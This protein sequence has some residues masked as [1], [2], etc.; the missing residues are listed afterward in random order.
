MPAYIIARLTVTDPRKY[1]KYK[2]LAPAAIAA[3]GGRYLTRGG[4]METLE[5][6]KE[7]R[8]LVLLEFP[9]IDKAREFYNS[10]EYAAAKAKRKGAAKGQFVLLE[11]L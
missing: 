1:E 8:R 2:A 3:H 6:F 9:S 7:G 5:G 4:A 11:G 10:A